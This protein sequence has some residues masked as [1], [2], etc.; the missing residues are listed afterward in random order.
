[1]DAK[2]YT[3]EDL[4][5]KRGSVKGERRRSAAADSDGCVHWATLN[6]VSALLKHATV[7]RF[8]SPL[9]VSPSCTHCVCMGVSG[10]FCVGKGRDCTPLT[11][12]P[13]EKAQEKYRYTTDS[14]TD[15]GNPP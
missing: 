1:M 10:C 9:C 7:G 4:K 12:K 6:N 14:Q 3:K 15:G 2:H 11:P 5:K 8:T 13:I